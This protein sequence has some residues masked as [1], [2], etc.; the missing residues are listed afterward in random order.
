MMGKSL[1][2]VKPGEGKDEAGPVCVRYAYAGNIASGLFT[3]PSNYKK[4]KSI[5]GVFA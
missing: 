5:M 4:E 2:S 1:R 3:K